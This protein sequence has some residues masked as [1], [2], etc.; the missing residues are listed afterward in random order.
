MPPTEVAGT[1]E[2]SVKPVAGV[3][4]AAEVT[5]PSASL[6]DSATLTEEPAA[7]L[8]AGQLGTIGAFAIEQGA[9]GVEVLRGGGG[10][11]ETVW[12]ARLGRLGQGDQQGALGGR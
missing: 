12:A 9:S 11:G 3:V 1:I 7:T 5:I 2:P 10:F 6:A 8:T 4:G